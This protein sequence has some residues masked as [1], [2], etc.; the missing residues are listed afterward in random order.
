MS[1]ETKRCA[2]YTRKS[3]EEGLEQEFN[4]LDAQRQAGTDYI[5][6]QKHEGWRAITKSYDDGGYSGGNTKRP[7]LKQLMLD[8]ERGEV[9]VV[10]VYKVDRLSRSLS[11]FA[12]LMKVFDDR[13]VSFVSVTQQFNTTTSM[14]RL[15]LNMLLSFAQFEREVTGERIRDKIAATKKQGLWAGGMSPLGYSLE[16]NRL[17]VIP[18]EADLVRMIF[19]GYLDHGSLVRLAEELNA[20]GRTTKYWQSHNGKWHGGKVITTGYLNK[21][22]TNPVYVGII[23]HKDNLWPG[24][25]EP[26]IDQKRWD[27]VRSAMDKQHRATRYTWTHPFLLKGKLRTS[28]NYAMSPGSVQR[29]T[30]TGNRKRL[31]R[32]YVSQKA[33]K[34][35]YKSCEIKT[36]NAKHLDELIR[37]LVLNHLGQEIGAGLSSQPA[38]ARDH[39]VRRVI[40]EV[41]VSTGSLCI[42]L[43]REKLSECRSQELPADPGTESAYRCAYTPVIDD[44]GDRVVLRLCIQIKKIDGKRLLLAPDGRDLILPVNPEPVSL[45]VEAIGRAYRVHEKLLKSGQ[46]ASALARELNINSTRLYKALSLT[47]LSPKILRRALDGSL[48][49]RTTMRDLYRAAESLDWDKQESMLCLHPAKRATGAETPASADAPAVA[50]P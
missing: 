27:H 18:E 32:Y 1:I 29:P 30:K 46:P 26:I 4:S 24:L 9:D 7:A 23:K 36:I 48:P 40:E 17:T 10:V 15:T 39:W 19:D 37:A 14:G 21:A 35:G 50:H 43:S 16:K 20:Q 6:S 38:E 13:G 41:T 22:L 3:H 31:V 12:Q 42:E 49:P 2:I 8:I 25:H 33:I 44:R 5:K 47:H 45:M 34:H 11:D 28:E